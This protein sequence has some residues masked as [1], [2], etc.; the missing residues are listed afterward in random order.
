MNPIRNIIRGAIKKRGDKLNILCAGMDGYFETLLA[1]TGHNIYVI[2]VNSKYA[3]N[4]NLPPRGKNCII[5]G[6]ADDIPI[7]LDLDLVICNDRLTQYELCAQ[8]THGLHVPMIVVEHFLPLGLKPQD[9]K[10]A[11]AAQPSATFVTTSPIVDKYWGGDSE[12]IGYGAEVPSYKVEKEGFVLVVGEFRGQETQIIGKL[13]QELPN[14]KL[15]GNNPPV[16]RPPSAESE[17]EVLYARAGIYLNLATDGR[18]PPQLIKAMANGCVIVSN[19]T[20]ALTG[21]LEDEKNC[22]IASSMMGYIESV[23]RIRE[24]RMLR[25]RLAEASLA[26]VADQFN[27]NFF[28]NKW[29]KVL[30]TTSNKVYVR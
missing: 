3:W 23:R 9:I 28:V 18:I 6:Q 13:I 22:L 19:N 26:T 24:D 5:L 27:M 17:L 30:E 14:I 25:E 2:P 29:N 12:I 11:R 16:S 4:T 21:I 7:D 8:L 1:K 20:P 10:Q 15:V